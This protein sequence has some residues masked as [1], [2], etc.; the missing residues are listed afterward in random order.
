MAVLVVA[1]QGHSGAQPQLSIQLPKGWF[2][3]RRRGK[4]LAIRKDAPASWLV[5]AGTAG[6]GKKKNKPPRSDWTNCQPEAKCVA[7]PI[8][9]RPQFS[10]CLAI[11][12]YING[13]FFELV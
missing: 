5:T 6:R 4:R 1:I 7:S 2:W 3:S 12:K 11:A 9:Q 8:G 13:R 10:S